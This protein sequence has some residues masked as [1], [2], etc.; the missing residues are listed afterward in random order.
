MPSTFKICMHKYLY[1]FFNISFPYKACRNTNDVGI[2]M[3][4]C[5]F[6]KLFS[7]ANSGTYMLMFISGYGYTVSTATN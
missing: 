2:I 1:H 4:A 3:F 5:K 6:S 7:P